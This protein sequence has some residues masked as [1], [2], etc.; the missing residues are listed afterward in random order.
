MAR[1]RGR[2]ALTCGLPQIIR[3]HLANALAQQ[4]NTVILAAQLS[5]SGLA[6]QGRFA[7]LRVAARSAF[8]DPG[9]ANRSLA[10][11]A[12]R[13]DGLDT[14]EGVLQHNENVGTQ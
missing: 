11:G 6:R 5:G 8:A 10:I 14:G 7:P 1:S 9:P 4:R 13:G 3:V 2:A 12:Y